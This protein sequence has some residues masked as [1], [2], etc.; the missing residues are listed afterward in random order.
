MSISITT[1]AAGKTSYV[2]G[3]NLMSQLASMPIGRRCDEIN[4]I[5]STWVSENEG[6]NSIEYDRMV[7]S[8]EDEMSYQVELFLDLNPLI[9]R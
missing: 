9:G 5:A 6:Y 1:N 7:E 2:F 8:L 4:E 3:I